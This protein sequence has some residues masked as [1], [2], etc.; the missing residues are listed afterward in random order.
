MLQTACW[1]HSDTCATSP[2]VARL[3]QPCTWGQ[4]TESLPSQVGKVGAWYR[5]VKLS[6]IKGQ[7]GVTEAGGVGTQHGQLAP[8][9]IPSHSIQHVPFL[10]WMCQITSWCRLKETHCQLNS[11]LGADIF[12]YFSKPPDLPSFPL[13]L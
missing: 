7:Q 9:A 1:Q 11:L 10:P 8:D 6:R 3:E 5:M 13:T 2:P 4:R 12:L